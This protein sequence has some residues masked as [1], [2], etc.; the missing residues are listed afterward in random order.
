MLTRGIS[1]YYSLFSSFSRCVP[2]SVRWL[3]VSDRKDEA[4]KI[5][6]KV[7]RVNKKQMPEDEL[8]VP[9]KKSKKGLLELFKT[10]RLITLSLIQCYAW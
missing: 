4:R 9:M 5:L 6:E 3:L 7:A 10:K 8:F 1:M 2:E